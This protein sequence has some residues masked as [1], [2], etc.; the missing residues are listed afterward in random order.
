MLLGVSIAVESASVPA[1]FENL[2][3][4]QQGAIDVYHQDRYVA[5][6]QSIYSPDRL[7]FSEPERILERL[8]SVSSKASLLDPLS[9]ELNTNT[10]LLCANSSQ[11]DCGLLAPDVVGIIFDESNFR[12]DLFI[13]P[14]L[15]RSAP[16]SQPEYLSGSSSG[17]SLLQNISAVVSG[18][19]G[20]EEAYSIFGKTTFAMS[21]SSVRA[22]WDI[23]NANGARLDTAFWHRD[24]RGYQLSAGLMRTNSAGLT[25]S[26]GQKILGMRFGTS[27]QT[28]LDRSELLGS[29]LEVF[30][31]SRARVAIFR[32]GRLLSSDYYPA[33]N[34]LLDSSRLPT[35]AY[36][37]EIRV[38]EDSGRQ[39]TS[40]RFFVKAPNL[41]SRGQPVYFIEAGRTL[42]D[43]SG[44]FPRDS[45]GWLARGGFQARLSDTLGLNLASATTGVESIVE[46]GLTAF[47]KI[48]RANASISASLGGDFGYALGA[49]QTFGKTSLSLDIRSLS[50]AEE[51]DSRPQASSDYPFTLLGGSFKQ[52]QLGVGVALDNGNL[53]VR[54]TYLEKPGSKGKFQHSVVFSRFF[55]KS[56][57][58]SLQIG[59]NSTGESDDMH[60]LLSIQYFQNKG[61]WT[62][63]VRPSWRVESTDNGKQT[64]QASID[65]SAS[66][67]WDNFVSG[68]ASL[69]ARMEADNQASNSFG[70]KSDYQSERGR[71]SASINSLTDDDKSRITYSARA[72]TSVLTDFSSIAWGGRAQSESAVMIDIESELS[73]VDFTVLVDDVPHNTVSTDRTGV[74][75]LSPYKSYNIRLR[76]DTPRFIGYSEKTE[77]ITLYPG[78]VVKLDWVANEILIAYGQIIDSEGN[79]IANATVD[80][81]LGSVRTDDS[82]IFQAELDLETKSLRVQYSPNCQV[83]LPANYQMRNG[84]AFL[85]VL[86]CH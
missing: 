70:L 49:F 46:G 73:D 77:N 17:F 63:R 27:W 34:Q 11:T 28:R 38:T 50:R 16:S 3:E 45:G 58:T 78:N 9:G 82:G 20:E 55:G 32:E 7:T 69:V 76:A 59:N 51:P 62:N 35:G 47:T 65:V 75:Q 10:D 6:I 74:V 4:P 39:T 18:E 52:Y 21:E 56:L 54:S 31:N 2:L 68:K 48:G 15:L 5:T 85:G 24:Y 80:G 84:V 1:G 19:T 79:P 12:A 53:A 37:I 83:E 26:S 40:N 61:K 29:R 13:N 8:E 67:Q 71:L 30:L 23:G 14:R 86:T 43:L 41:P 66:R 72:E 42:D 64:S 25:F 81:A 57:L 44:V 22:Q 36:E 33:G 60:A